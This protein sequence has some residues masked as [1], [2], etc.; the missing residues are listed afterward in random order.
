MDM[1]LIVFKQVVILVILVMMGIIGVRSK[2]V[3]PGVFKTLSNILL[4]FVNPFLIIDSLSVEYDPQKTAGFLLSLA[5]SVGMHIVCILGA[6]FLF[7]RKGDPE[8]LPIERYAVVLSNAGYIGIPLINGIFGKEAVFYLVAYMVCFNIFSWT[9]GM[10]VL[11]KGRMDLK[12]MLINPGNIGCA[13]GLTIYFL[14]IPLP[15]MVRTVISSTANVNTFLSLFAIGIICAGL[16]I[17][18]L[19]KNRRGLYVALCRLVLL[20]VIVFAVLIWWIPMVLPE[21]G[22]LVASVLTVAALTPTAMALSF[23][24]QI[25]GRNPLYGSNLL[26]LST[27]LCCV[28]V[29]VMTTILTAV[30]NVIY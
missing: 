8:K 22:M 2:K 30:L 5:V 16:N 19:L 3:D 21:N 1:A 7:L 24:C 20:P 6:H 18:D 23:M 28:T 17:P 11:Q 13:I 29:P 27:V 25:S 9:Y 14:R 26:A 15:G 4:Y 10:W 12:K